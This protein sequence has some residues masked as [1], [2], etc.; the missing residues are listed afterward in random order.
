MMRNTRNT[1][2]EGKMNYSEKKI[3]TMKKDM[4][5]VLPELKALLNWGASWPRRTCIAAT[6]FGVLR[7]AERAMTLNGMRDRQDVELEYSL[8]SVKDIILR[9][10]YEMKCQKASYGDNGENA[11]PAGD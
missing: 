6:G 3:E 2:T 10:T 4:T 5:E 1:Q 8:Q 7:K 11:P 9:G